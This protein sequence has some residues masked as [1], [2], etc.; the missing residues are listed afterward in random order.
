MGESFMIVNLID[1]QQAIDGGCA[2][3]VRELD[4]LGRIGLHKK[5]GVS[6]STQDSKSPKDSP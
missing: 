5:A 6:I 4:P 1:E 3:R 2:S